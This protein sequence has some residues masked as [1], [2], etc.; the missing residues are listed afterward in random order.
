MTFAL[1]VACALL[2]ILIC[3]AAGS[4]IG[5]RSRWPGADMLVG[6]GLLTGSLAILAI[7]TRLPLTWLMGG[8]AAASAI[9][10]IVRRPAPG[11]RSTWIAIALLSPVLVKAAGQEPVG[12]DDFWN[13]LPSAAYEY[14]RNSLPWPDLPASLS[15]FPGYPQGMPLMIAA[16][17][18]IAGRFLESAG[19]VINVL[20]LAGSSALLAEALG[21]ALMR[22]GRLHKTEPPAVLV[23]IGVLITTLLNPGLN[24]TVVL[25]SYADCATMVGVGALG[26][27]GAEIVARLSSQQPANVEGLSWRFGLVGAMLVNLKQANPIL[28]ILVTA[29]L[30][31]VVLRDPAVPKR[32]AALQLPR[33]LGPAILLFA[34]WRWYV[35]HNLPNSEQGFRPFATWNFAA[36]PSTFTSIGFYIAEAPLFHA[37]MWSVCAAGL[38]SLF[39]FSRKAGDAR[40]LAIIGATVWLGYNAFLVLVYLGAMSTSDAYGAADYWRYTPHVALLGLYPPVMAVACA[41][42]PTWLPLRS[43]RA[44]LPAICTLI[45]L[46]LCVPLLRGDIRHVPGTAWQRFVRDAVIDMRHTIPPGSKLVILSFSFA[47]GSPFGVAVRYYLWQFDAAEQPIT[48]TIR[49]DDRDLATLSTAAARGEID[50]LIIQDEDGDMRKATDVLGI[51]PL[52]HE[53]ALFGWRRGAWERLQ[54]WPIPP[55]LIHSP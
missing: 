22:Q 23:A 6:F 8:L 12:W 13:W 54:S 28:F 16:A 35:T 37:L 48:T 1:T 39:R 30:V 34:V 26:L 32:R 15:I 4:T 49:W 44:T 10:L 20:L 33:M 43:A 11:G 47:D 2:P 50:Y 55:A 53:L 7:I 51:P 40:A 5:D 17:S 41:R 42:W 46:A 21:T 36:L 19:G 14:H 9:A 45:L 38:F 31:L 52:Q 27:L 29:G 18:F 25:S 3:I 24:G